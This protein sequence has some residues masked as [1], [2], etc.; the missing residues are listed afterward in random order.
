[1]PTVCILFLLLCELLLLYP[2]QSAAVHKASCYPRDRRLNETLKTCMSSVRHT[3]LLRTTS[4]SASWW[5]TVNPRLQDGCSF[6]FSTMELYLKYLRF[7]KDF[8]VK[9]AI[10]PRCLFRF[11]NLGISCKKVCECF[12]TWI[13]AC[14]GLHNVII[15]VLLQIIR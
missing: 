1:M 6:L 15:T 2:E 11:T 13:I 5:I 9:V 12:Y 8:M 14:S 3:L 10:L 4:T 7:L